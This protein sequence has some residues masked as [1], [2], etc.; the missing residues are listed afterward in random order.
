[1]RIDKL[2]GEKKSFSFHGKK[3]ENDDED[4]DV[5]M[6]MM[7]MNSCSSLLSIILIEGKGWISINMNT[8]K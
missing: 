6:M 2:W 1:M 3:G 5:T 4:E 7:M 8:D